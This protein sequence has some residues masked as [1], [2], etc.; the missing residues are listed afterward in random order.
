MLLRRWRSNYICGLGE[1]LRA[2]AGQPRLGLALRGLREL[3]IYLAV[4]AWWALLLSV[5]FWPGSVAARLA[6]FALLLVAPVLLMAWR[7]RSFT[8]ALYAVVSWCF[9]AAGLL[10]GLLRP[11]RPAGEAIAS[12]ILHLPGAV[13]LNTTSGAAGMQA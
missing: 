9:N 13:S 3:R 1:L 2:A 8:K 6:S 7:K 4:L 10:R 5:P 12:R 11:Q